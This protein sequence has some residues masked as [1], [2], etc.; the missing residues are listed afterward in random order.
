MVTKSDVH[1]MMKSLGIRSDDKVTMH[2]SLKAIGEIENGAEGLLDA[3][4]EYLYD[5]LLIIPTHTWLGVL[6]RPYYSPKETR[7][8]IGV[9]PNIAA[10][11]PD[12]VRSLHPSHSV[13]VFGRG[14]KEYVD[15]E[16][17]FSTP[18]GPDNCVSRLYEEHGKILLVGVGFECNTYLHAVEEYLQI[19]NRFTS[20]VYS[21]AIKDYTGEIRKVDYRGHCVEG[22]PYGISE[23]YPVLEKPLFHLGGLVY[24]TLGNAKVMCCDARRTTEVYKHLWDKMQCDFCFENKPIPE[25]YY[26]NDAV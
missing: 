6:E 11:H 1:E 5:G 24:G 18:L 26:K 21:L 12:A 16:K 2:T 19:P 25:E 13:A 3:L 23:H 9:L 17:D 20:E 7:S 14:A 8:C 4:R 15:K 10:F 22:L